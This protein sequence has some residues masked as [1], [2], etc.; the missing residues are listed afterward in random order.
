MAYS[1]LIVEDCDFIREL[2]HFNLKGL[3]IQIIGEAR[4]GTEALE[5]IHALHPD[6]II[7][8]LVLP[9]INGFDILSQVHE[10]SPKSKVLIVSTL[11]D[12]KS[13]KKAKSLGAVGYLEKPFTKSDLIEAVREAAQHYDGVQNG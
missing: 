1:C 6:I 4:N 9:E 5:K 10:I 2:Y 3:E 11:D 13:K 7:L 12:A 8:D